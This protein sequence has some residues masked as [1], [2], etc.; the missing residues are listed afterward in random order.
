MEPTRSRRATVRGPAAN[1]AFEGGSPASI[2]L[3][4]GCESALD[5]GD[6]AKNEDLMLHENILLCAKT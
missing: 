5:E 6:I 1:L 2:G 4:G 3:F